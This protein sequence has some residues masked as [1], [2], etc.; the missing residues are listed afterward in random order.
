MTVKAIEWAVAPNLLDAV[1]DP[2]LVFSLLL[3]NLMSPRLWEFASRMQN[4]PA[5]AT[6]TG[7]LAQ[8]QQF[9]DHHYEHVT[10][11]HVFETNGVLDLEFE[12]RRLGASAVEYAHAKILSSMESRVR[13]GSYAANVAGLSRLRR[14]QLPAYFYSTI[15][16]AYAHRR[17]LR[18][19]KHKPYGITCCIDEAALFAALSI[20]RR[21]TSAERLMFLA[22]P[23]HHTALVRTTDH[24]WWFYGKHDLFS[25]ADWKTLVTRSHKGDPQVAFDFR[26][27][28]LDRIMTTAGSIFF[29]NGEN[30]M[31]EANLAARVKLIDA[32]FGTRLAQLDQALR[33]GFRPLENTHLDEIFAGI[34][35]ASDGP[36]VQQRLSRLAF[37][38]DQPAALRALYAFRTLDV[39]DPNVY[40]RAAR[41]AALRN[42]SLPQPASIDA[43]VDQ[44][45]AIK[46]C[47]SIFGDVTRIAMPDET[48][49]FGTGSDR[50][51]ALLLHVILEHI[52]DEKRLPSMPIETIITDADSYVIVPP[53]RFSFR[54]MT[55]VASAE[56][57]PLYR[58]GG[59]ADQSRSC[60]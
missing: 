44:V 35:G 55:F 23:A 15:D 56:G 58:F 22:S 11:E 53:L 24:G 18:G 45:A 6:L 3:A 46:G 29:E 47:E 57:K 9:I 39:P 60:G 43:A 21:I 7:D 42:H 33:R 10:P 12:A 8:V 54:N 27:P 37:Q 13:R 16:E 34:N 20:A 4:R 5:T 31:S 38:E 30:S 49:R 14:H 48:I 17:L 40:L 50:D 32:F 26:L 41:T 36:A 52:H 2:E 25:S 59:L 28:N 19:R 51:K 1:V